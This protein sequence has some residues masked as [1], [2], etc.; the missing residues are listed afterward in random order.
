MTGH[1]L[2]SM[3]EPGEVSP[4]ELQRVGLT[5]SCLVRVNEQGDI[6]LSG[7]VAAPGPEHARPWVGSYRNY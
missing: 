5:D 1:A 4:D 6:E 2:M 7:R 3:V